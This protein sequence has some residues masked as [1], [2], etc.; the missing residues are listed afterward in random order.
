MKRTTLA[1]IL[2]LSLISC[3]KNVNEYDASGTFEAE[4]TIISAEATGIIRQLNIDE[5]M[6]LV[7]GQMIGYIDTTQLQLKREQLKQQI[8]AVL[9]KSPNKV[10]QMASLQE[11]LKQAIHEKERVDNLVKEGAATLKQLD[12]AQAQVSV[13]QSQLSALKSS[14]NITTTSIGAETSPLKIQIDQLNDQI[15]KSRIINPVKGT[16]LTQYTRVNEMAVIGKPLYKIADLSSIILRAYITGDQLLSVKLDQQVKVIVDD[17]K[18]A[19]KEYNGIIDWIS[20]KSEFTPKTIQTKDERANLVYAIKVRVVND[21]YL[22]IGMYGE[23][24]F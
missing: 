12:D 11:Q 24:K 23:V 14:L 9:S 21:G 17:S 20:S 4:E 6:E 13:L 3:K 15:N 10:L 8:N 22:K 19:H 7:P 5:G 18:G 16:I 1:I 2:A